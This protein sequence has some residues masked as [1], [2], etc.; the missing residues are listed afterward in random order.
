MIISI[1]DFTHKMA[2]YTK[3]QYNLSAIVNPY[4]SQEVQDWC[5]Y[6]ADRWCYLY[7]GSVPEKLKDLVPRFIPAVS[8]CLPPKL[9]RH[10]IEREAI[11]FA[12]SAKKESDYFLAPRFMELQ[13]V[14]IPGEGA[15]W[16]RY[17]EPFLFHV[18][19]NILTEEQMYLFSR[20]RIDSIFLPDKYEGVV[21]VKK[22]LPW[23]KKTDKS[24]I[25]LSPAQMEDLMSAQHELFIN[26]IAYNLA[27]ILGEEYGR[28]H[29]YAHL[30]ADM[31]VSNGIHSH[32]GLRDFIFLATRGE[33]FWWRDNVIIRDILSGQMGE[34]EKLASLAGVVGKVHSS[35]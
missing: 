28:V 29:N 2:D 25:C 9:V 7:K 22:V 12:S 14:I 30:A 15:V 21:Y 26:S 35:V 19:L 16:F 23:N 8:T 24:Q 17:Y 33:M 4:R 31:A 11:F 5:D 20:N 18:F 32:D 34:K 10:L 1:A 13:T 6:Y 3:G 27:P